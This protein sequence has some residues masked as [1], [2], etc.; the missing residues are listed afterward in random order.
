MR[1]KLRKIVTLGKF[2]T[3]SLAEAR[4]NALKRIDGPE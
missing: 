3:L 1:G 2:P 4:R